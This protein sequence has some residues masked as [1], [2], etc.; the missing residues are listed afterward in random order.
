MAKERH[1]TAHH[2]EPPADPG[3]GAVPRA[4]HEAA[5]ARIAELEQR[6]ALG[7]VTATPAALLVAATAREHG[8]GAYWTVE[9]QHAPV[10]V[11]R[12]VDPANAWEEYKVELGV[13]SS[14]HRPVVKPA[15]REEYRLAQARRLGLQPEEF[16]LPEEAPQD[17]T[18]EGK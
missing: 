14:E 1:L 15:S 17:A 6:L 12:A 2:T 8:H 3:A 13:I 4:E 7:A 9:L 16:K 11:V 10:H 5:L 18:E